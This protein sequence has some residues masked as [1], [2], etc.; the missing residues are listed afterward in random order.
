M[1]PIGDTLFVSKHDEIYR[2]MTYRFR[3]VNGHFDSYY[4]NISFAVFYEIITDLDGFLVT[5]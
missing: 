1:A 2:N 4:N 3:F 5:K